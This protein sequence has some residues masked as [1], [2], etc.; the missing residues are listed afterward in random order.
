MKDP[1]HDL[2]A[3]A[4]PVQSMGLSVPSSDPARQIAVASGM[5]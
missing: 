2:N 4:F 5:V 1:S 3:L